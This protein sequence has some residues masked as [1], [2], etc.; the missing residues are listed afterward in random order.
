MLFLL[1]ECV[2]A[3]AGTTSILEVANCRS[4]CCEALFFLFFPRFFVLSRPPPVNVHTTPFQVNDHHVPKIFHLER[5][6]LPA[7]GETGVRP[8][9]DQKA[10]LSVR[11]GAARRRN[12]KRQVCVIL[13]D[14]FPLT[15][16]IL[17]RRPIGWHGESGAARSGG[18]LTVD[19]RCSD[20]KHVVTHH[21][22]RA[23]RAYSK[24]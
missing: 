17:S 24:K 21:V 4:V 20:N 8:K 15:K 18:H 5:A 7:P 12:R 3:L 9:A 10:L 14:A 13:N 19:F 1:D 11:V 22:Y 16:I 6:V 2:D 23:N